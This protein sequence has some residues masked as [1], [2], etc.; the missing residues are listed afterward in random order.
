MRVW[1][2]SQHNSW[3]LYGHSHGLLSPDGKRGDIGVDN[4]QFY[5]LSFEQLNMLMLNRPDNPDMLKIKNHENDDTVT[6]TAC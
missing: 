1:E 2:R 3:Q 5:P 6:T 4:N